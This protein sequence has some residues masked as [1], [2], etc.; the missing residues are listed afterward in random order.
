M[1]DKQFNQIGALKITAA[2]NFGFDRVNNMNYEQ[3]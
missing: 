3:F 2:R 1:R